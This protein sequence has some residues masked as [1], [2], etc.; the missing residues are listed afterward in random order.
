MTILTEKKSVAENYI[1]ALKLEKKE[2]GWY[3]S[4]DGKINLTYAAG[5]LYTLYEPEDYN[6]KDSD[7]Y[8]RKLPIKPNPYKYKPIY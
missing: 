2:N 8:Q 3:V 4:K 1:K 7:W 6:A 5:H